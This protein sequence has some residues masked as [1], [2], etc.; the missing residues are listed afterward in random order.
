MGTEKLRVP[1]MSS[2]W[3]ILQATLTGLGTGAPR[4]STARAL[5]V[6]VD[7]QRTMLGVQ[8]LQARIEQLDGLA[9]RQ[10]LARRPWTR[11]RDGCR[12]FSCNSAAC[13][14][15]LIR[16]LMRRPSTLPVRR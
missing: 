1:S 10:W 7:S 13:A 16:D 6:D 14:T 15:D 2:V 9:S 4:R 8:Q 11:G 5:N 3:A 12:S